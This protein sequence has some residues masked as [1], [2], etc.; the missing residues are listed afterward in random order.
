MDYAQNRSIPLPL[1]FLVL[2]VGGFF[3]FKAIPKTEPVTFPTPVEEVLDRPEKPT[4]TPKNKPEGKPQGKPDGNPKP[5]VGSSDDDLS[6]DE[7]FEKNCPP[8]TARRDLYDNEKLLKEGL[9]GGEKL[10]VQLR[11]DEIG[12]KCDQKQCAAVE[13]L[14]MQVIP[15]LRTLTAQCILLNVVGSRCCPEVAKRVGEHFN[16]QCD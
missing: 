12:R 5:F 6:D 2:L 8:N 1:V 10:E 4:A 14:L 15:R 16:L 3:L 11:I 7:W 13:A 9:K